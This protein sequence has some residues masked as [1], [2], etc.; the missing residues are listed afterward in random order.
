MDD[1]KKY[2]LGQ[3]ENWIHDALSSAEATPSEIYNTIIDVIVEN[4]DYH[5]K[6]LMQS[7]ELLARMRGSRPVKSEWDKW[8]ETYYPEEVKND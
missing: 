1:Y 4:R 3:L 5:K 6:C 8:E 2:S 7:N